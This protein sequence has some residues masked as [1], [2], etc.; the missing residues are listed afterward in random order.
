MNQPSLQP[1]SAVHAAAVAKAWRFALPAL[2]FTLLAI[3]VLYRETAAAMVDIWARSETFTHAF[4]VPPISLW[5]IWRIRNDVALVAPRPSVWPL[6]ALAGAGLVW[7]LGELAAVGVLSQFALMSMLVLAVPAVLGLSVARRILFPLA[8]LFFAVPFG[9]F[10]MPQMMEWTANATILGLRMSGIPVYREGLH[11]VI[12]SGSWSVIEAC[13]GV[14]YLIASVTVGTLFAYLSYHSLKRRLIFVVV[15]FVVP[16]IANWVRAY[17]IVML[18]H[19]SGNKLAAGV[20]HLIYGWVFFG[21]VIIAMF[22]IGAR[23]REDDLPFSA[24]TLRDTSKAAGKNFLLLVASFAAVATATVWPLVQWEIERNL[25][26]DVSRLE[27]LGP[28]S[29]WLASAENFT[30][31]RPLFENA[32]AEMQSAFASEGRMVGLY[33]GYYRNQGDDRK[34]VTSGNVLVRSTDPHWARV[35][36]GA[37]QIALARQPVNVRTAELRSSADSLRMVVWQWYWVNGHLT[38]SDFQ[39]KAYTAFYRLMG[40]GD[41]SAVIIIYA[42]KEQA[43]GGEAAL[44]AFAPVAAPEIERLLS[45]TREKR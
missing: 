7:L 13:S 16:V 9:E 35:A 30:D 3:L 29:G 1:A 33:L 44:E 24:E 6:L 4:L 39:A 23:W 26:P 17:I 21:I 20:D 45:G 19:L 15:S 27:A 37:R 18:G 14:R 11:F 38:D 42:P 10:A 12:P 40:Q 22:W 28:I 2:V 25:P 43:G 32:S 31:W 5:L 36:S 41:D 34:M 8:F